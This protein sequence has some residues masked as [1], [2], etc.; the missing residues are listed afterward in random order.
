MKSDLS[1]RIIFKIITLNC[2]LWPNWTRSSI[3]D[4]EDRCVKII[5]FIQQMFTD[6]VDVICLQEVFGEYWKNIIMK[7]LNNY[8]PNTQLFFSYDSSKRWYQVMDSGLLTISKHKIIKSS[9]YP[10]T[11]SSRLLNFANKGFLIT[12]ITPLENSDIPITLINTHLQCDEYSNCLCENSHKIRLQQLQQI[13]K[14]SYG[15]GNSKSFYNSNLIVGDFNFD[16]SIDNSLSSIH[17]KHSWCDHPVKFQLCDGMLFPDKSF[18]IKVL[19]NLWEL[20]DHYPV[21]LEIQI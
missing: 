17:Y 14:Y 10:F 3:Y 5:N 13:Y 18:E 8:Y 9:F 2:C 4:N 6:N 19:N 7:A 16:L 11:K 15:K 12:E 20:S 1:E 21:E